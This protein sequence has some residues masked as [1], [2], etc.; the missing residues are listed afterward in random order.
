[1]FISFTSVNLI[2]LISILLINLSFLFITPA[3]A[4]STL[5]CPSSAT[6]NS[7]SGTEYIVT[8]KTNSQN[9][10]QLQIADILK[11]LKTTLDK[12]KDI[13]DIA[14][15]CSNIDPLNI[16]S[17][18]PNVISSN[19]YFRD[20][21]FS[22]FY[23]F[24]GYYNQDF[25][26]ALSE[27][28]AVSKVQPIVAMKASGLINLNNNQPNQPDVTQDVTNL[29]NLDRIDQTSRPLDGKYTYPSCA[30]K[31][32]NMYIV[33]TGIDI[34][35]KEFGGR[36]KYGKSCCIGCPPC[37]WD[38]HGHGTHV[39]GI[40]GSITYGVAK[41]INLIAVKV[42]NAAGTGTDADIIAGLQ[43]VY[44]DFLKK[45]KPS[46]VNMSLGGGKSDP[47]NAAVD[48][49]TAAGI[50][51]SV[52]AGNSEDDACQYSP[53]SAPTAIAVGAIK[54]TDNDALSSYSCYGT[55]VPIYAP[56]DNILSTFVK[57]IVDSTTAT[58]SGTSMASPHVAG[59]IALYQCSNSTKMTPSE[60]RNLLISKSDKKLIG[61]LPDGSNNCILRIPYTDK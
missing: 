30:G 23:A 46:I 6:T 5:N 26:N 50:F 28:D 41:A 40:V 48:A 24:S 58:L 8:L 21:S 7:D 20:L 9:E 54:N 35:H 36:A 60:M 29:W 13:V 31:D 19:Q 10:A 16:P 56:G 22:N 37:P 39:S 38:D 52:A 47:L 59:A 2:S 11:C 43:F 3:N 17:T 12:I 44:N 27:W 42:L 25:V 51:V 34:L 1:M 53:A 4:G 57:G 15:Q 14:N 49:I 55:C 18:V 45:K 61:N 33:D 32:T